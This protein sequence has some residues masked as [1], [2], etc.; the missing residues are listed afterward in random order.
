MIKVQCKL[1]GK[2]CSG[3]TNLSI[4]FFGD[5]V[6]RGTFGHIYDVFLSRNSEEEEELLEIIR[7]EILNLL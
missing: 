1:S 7:L 3:K 2:S 6:S 4:I 5:T